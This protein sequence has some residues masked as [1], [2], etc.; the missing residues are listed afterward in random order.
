MAQIELAPAL[1]R[2]PIQSQPNSPIPQFALPFPLSFSYSTS[3]NDIGSRIKYGLKLSF[4]FDF[5]SKCL[6]L[7]FI[8]C[9]WFMRIHAVLIIEKWKWIR[10]QIV[11]RHSA[12]ELLWLPTCH[13]HHLL[14]QFTSW[15]ILQRINVRGYRSRSEI[16]YKTIGISLFHSRFDNF[17]LLV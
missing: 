2:S 9:C 11:R 4:P 17:I 12:L 10:G 14:F 5:F 7:F 15:E 1:I 3:S 6:L 8:V 16:R 13:F